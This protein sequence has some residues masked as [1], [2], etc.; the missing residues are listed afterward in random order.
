[1]DPSNGSTPAQ[2]TL[3]DWAQMLQLAPPAD[4]KPD[5]QPEPVNVLADA[6][7][8]RLAEELSHRLP[9]PSAATVPTAARLLTLDQ[10]ITELPAAKPRIAT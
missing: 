10:L 4:S 5:E 8:P 6:L 3:D 7:A 9:T 1:M 2:L